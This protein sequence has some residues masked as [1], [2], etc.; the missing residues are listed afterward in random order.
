MQ[1]KVSQ[2]SNQITYLNSQ[3]AEHEA[4]I[5]MREEC[6]AKINEYVQELVEK[7]MQL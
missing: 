4:D 2:N 5:Q 6:E 7:N 1:G 3:V